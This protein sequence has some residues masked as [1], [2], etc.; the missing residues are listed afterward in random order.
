MPKPE[1]HKNKNMMNTVN[2]NSVAWP[3][4]KWMQALRLPKPSR[5]DAQQTKTAVQEELDAATDSG[6]A[7]AELQ[8]HFFRGNF[9][10]GA[11]ALIHPSLLRPDAKNR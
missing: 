10:A 8:R 7:D 4:L 1:H 9:S 11:T 3:L 6:F 5:T 2:Q